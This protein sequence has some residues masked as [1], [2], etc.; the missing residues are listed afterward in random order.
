MTDLILSCE[1]Q[2]RYTKILKVDFGNGLPQPLGF[3]NRTNG[4][5]FVLQV[6]VLSLVP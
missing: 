3:P 1:F 4:F 5:P 2:A 6:P